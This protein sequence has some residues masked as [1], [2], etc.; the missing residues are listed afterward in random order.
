MNRGAKAAGVKRIRIH[1][2]RHSHVAHCIELGF[3]P[4]AIAERM[5]HEGI[6]ITFNYAHLYPSKQKALADK[7]NE[8]RGNIAVVDEAIA[9]E[10]LLSEAVK[11]TDDRKF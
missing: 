11:G 1:D 7:L 10:S 3:S 9:E 2:L 8:D 6:N 5:G 4:V